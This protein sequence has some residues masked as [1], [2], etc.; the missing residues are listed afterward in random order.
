MIQSPWFQINQ[1][2]FMKNKSTHNNKLTD[3]PIKPTRS[4]TAAVVTY[5]N[6]IISESGTKTLDAK[7]MSSNLSISG[8]AV[9]SLT[10]NSSAL[11]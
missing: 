9:E 7:T 1:I 4:Q 5:N 6:L 11:I 3:L 2:V 10:A 8:T